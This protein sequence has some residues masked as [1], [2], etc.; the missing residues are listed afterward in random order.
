MRD[1]VEEELMTVAVEWDRAMVENDTEAIERFMADDW[2]IIGPDGSIGDK[3]NFL[4]LVSSGA[5][6]H[7]VMES[8][9]MQ[10]RV[11]GDTAVVIARGISGGKFH[12][13]P[14]YLVERASSVFVRQDGRWRCVSTH[15]SQMADKDPVGI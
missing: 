14:F 2:T 4:G 8:H 6:T 1:K 11:Y 3:A 13:Q 5:L 10:V 7:D 9:D 15:L 12:G